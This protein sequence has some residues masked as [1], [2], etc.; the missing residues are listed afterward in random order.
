MRHFKIIQSRNGIIAISLWALMVSAT[1]RAELRAGTGVAD[2]TPPPGTPSAGYGGRGGR[3]MA[4]THDPLLATALA[5]DNGVKLL[6]FCGVDH[7]GMT[8]DMIGEIAQIVRA[9]PSMAKAELYIG[10]SHTHAGGGAFMNVPGLGYILAGRY[11]PEK[12]RGYIEG[13]A[14]AILAAGKSLQ[15]AKVGIGYG[16]APGL[17]RYRGDW[18]RG[19]ETVD[20]VAVIKVTKSDGSPLA[21]LFNFAA[22][23]TVLGD[24]N[25]Q[26]S[27]DWVGYARKHIEA[28]LGG[29]QAIFFNGAQADVTPGAPAGADEFDKCDKMGAVMAEVVKKAWDTTNASSE[30]TIASLNETYSQ[31]PQ[32][33]SVGMKV[34]TEARSTEINGIVFNGKHAFVTIP[35][36]ISCIYDRDLKRYAGWLG[37]EHLSLLGLTNDAH[38]YIILPE[39]WRHRTYESTISFGGEMYGEFVKSKVESILHVLEPSEAYQ[40]DKANYPSNLMPVGKQ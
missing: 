4:G 33:N 36:E 28:K 10:S 3:G 39:A 12:R 30:L 1:V 14:K 5:L 25:M 38:G 22:H 40:H 17:N 37:F 20:D 35:G 29:G 24:K 2:I 18:P 9:E 8:A 13:T 27:A 15:P 34:Q 32:A 11:D 16:H 21:C 19:I 31:S 23:P 6:V 26:F 7:L